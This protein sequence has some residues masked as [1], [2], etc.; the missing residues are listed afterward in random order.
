MVVSSQLG[1]FHAIWTE[2]DQMVCA[3]FICDGVW[4]L[5]QL[6]FRWWLLL[7]SFPAETRWALE[8][9][10]LCEFDGCEDIFSEMIGLAEFK[11]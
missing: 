7:A 9:S 3:F 8:P 4:S 6:S 5:L 2:Q 11:K 1:F 10:A